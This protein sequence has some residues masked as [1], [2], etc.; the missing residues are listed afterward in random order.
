MPRALALGL[1]VVAALPARADD[2]IAP[3]TVTAT[4]S[5]SV[6]VRVEG[7]DWKGSG[8]GF[9]VTVDKDNV[10]VVTNHHVVLKPPPGAPPK[11]A[12]VRVVFGSGTVAE[13]EYRAAVVAAD[14]ERDLAV[15]RVTD[16][17]DPPKPIAYLDPPKPVET[18]SVY[19][20]GF[21]LGQALA[22]GKGAPA[23]TVGKASV[24]SLREGSDGELATIQIDGNLN[25]GNSGGPVVDGKGRLVGVA[26]A[27][28]RDGQ[29]IGFLVPAA[30]VGRLMAGRVERVRVST[31][32]GDGGRPIARVE[33]EVID[34]AGAVRSVTA[35]CV[36][37]PPKEKA[38]DAAAL[39][40]HPRA[41]KV[42][43]KVD[44]GLAVGELAIDKAEGAVLV[45][46]IGDRGA[47]T[48]A[49]ATRPR[50][51]AL[52]PGL[53]PGDLA[54]PPPAGWKEHT[55]RG[56]EF[57][58]WLPEKP[59]RQTE[60]RRNFAL[61]ARAFPAGGVTGET[62]DGLGY[63]AETVDL[64]PTLARLAADLFPA[65]R[66]S[67]RDE[68]A[69]R[70]TESVQAQI[71]T[72]HGAEFWLESRTGITR[73]RAYVH[74]R[75]IYLVRVTGTTGQVSGADAETILAS[76]RKPG[77][78]QAQAPATRPSPGK[79]AEP[80]VVPS[81]KEP[82]I[83]GSI[84]HDPKFKTIGP[85]GAI[86]IG[87]EARFG[88]FGDLDIVRAVRP[89]YRVNGKEEF[90]KQFGNDLKG[91]V[92]LKAKD[93][94]AVGGV[95]GKA[96]WWCNGFALT[97]MKVKPDGTLDPKDSYESE[98][99]GFNGKGDVHRVMTDGAPAVGI[100]GKIVGHETTAFGLLFK[101]Q[102]GFETNPSAPV[103]GAPGEPKVIALGKEPYILGSIEHDPK[104]KTIGPAGAILIG[105]EVRFGKFGSTDIARAVRPIYRVDGEEEFG[106]QFGRD[107]RG[108]ITLKAKDG[109][110]VGAII[111]KAGWWCNGFALTFM[112]VKPDGTL[113][114]KD[115][116]DSP[117]VG[118]DGRGEVFKVSGD[119]APVVG[120]VG[121]IVGA[122]TTALG[123]VFKG[124]EKFAVGD[125][126]GAP[127]NPKVTAAG[128][129]AVTFGGEQNRAF[130]APGPDGAIL[131]GLELSIEEAIGEDCINGVRPIYRVTSGGK[132]EIKIGE[133]YGAREDRLVTLKA[134]AGYAVGAM[135][136]KYS[137]DF[138]GCLLT[139]MKIKAD[140]T[141]DPK[142]CYDSE[143][144]GWKGRANEGRIDGEGKPVVGIVGR[145]D[146][147]E[148]TGFGLLFKGQTFDPADK[149]K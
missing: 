131:V 121:K 128:K 47:K 109:Y 78:L 56:K 62:E 70:I 106:R 18:M 23:V 2:A 100:V 58:V 13:R 63:R 96:G 66:S 81:G 54:G 67:L 51:F 1:L 64:P 127:V 115:S 45:Q 20:F 98:W 88:K 36:V 107:M 50:A 112:K 93:G 31:G 143:W 69:G 126:S 139:F 130:E 32:K 7:D 129:E 99:A 118:F 125:G 4:K 6:Y 117:W 71:G 89:I 135:T 91:A 73:V 111:G 57:S 108:A 95:T 60:E 120:I 105:L 37:V 49:V 14:E 122:E 80:N 5:A 77:D 35:Y 136:Y 110:A 85:A 84:A 94:Y 52:A 114:P 17:K 3:E 22:T 42:V 124:Q 137:R 97:F 40:K 26:V 19:S 59:A 113:D 43:L 68:T 119:G 25:P 144:I 15:L 30:E 28:I 9:V 103:P 34:P 39:D 33:A 146:A 12:T 102:E 83:L 46:V 48:E 53:T 27:R 79:P 55:S 142:D 132:T 29:G 76:F 72:L 90:G 148:V 116:Y 133:R 123:L 82:F 74:D 10:L 11:P 61:G 8:S 140:G 134:R 75:R 101:G 44:N 147:K 41:K 86:L 138:D 92:T 104:F 16:V 149:N 145:G 38:P 24:S 141:L 21:P 65:I 87:V